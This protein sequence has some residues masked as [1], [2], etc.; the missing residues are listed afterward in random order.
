VQDYVGD[1]MHPT[2]LHNHNSVELTLNLCGITIVGAIAVS[3]FFGFFFGKPLSPA[4]CAAAICNC[5]ATVYLRTL[6]LATIGGLV[7]PALT[8]LFICQS[9]DAF[10]SPSL[11]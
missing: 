11:I 7:A 10:R 4:S 8:A 5:D 1:I 9:P 3:P 2:M 6:W